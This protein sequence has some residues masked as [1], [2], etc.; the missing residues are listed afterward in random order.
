MLQ[1]KLHRA[2]VTCADLDYEGSCGIDQALL[3][4]SGLRENQ[5]IEIY[6][7][8]NGERFSTYIIPAPR[9]SGGDLA[10][11]RG[12]PQGDGGRPADHRGLLRLQRSGACNVPPRRRAARRAQP[13]EADAGRQAGAVRLQSRVGAVAAATGSS[14]HFR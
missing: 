10:E 8:N 4:L 11:R 6:N 7:I 13:P 12:R 3:E 14:L 9:G 2:R 5:Y 1:A